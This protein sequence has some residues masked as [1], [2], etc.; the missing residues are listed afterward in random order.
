MPKEATKSRKA[1]GKAEGKRKKGE[2]ELRSRPKSTL[3]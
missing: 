2:S 3:T 1:K